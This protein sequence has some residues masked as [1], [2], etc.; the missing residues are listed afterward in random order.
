MRLHISHRTTYAY[1]TP[2]RRAVETLRLTPR[3]HDGQF[4]IGWR[5]DVD[6]DCILEASADPFGNSV[7]SFTA[8]GP[9]ESL[10]ITAEGT[11]ETNDTAGVVHGQ[12]E[13]FPPVFFLRD[14][15]L[16]RADGALKA[17]ADDIAAR[18]GSGGVDLM[19]RVM[20]AIRD[21]MRFEVDLT[22]TGTTAADAFRL[23]HGVC[24]D[25]AH[26]FIA[27]A[28]QLGVPARYAGGYLLAGDQTEAYSA[29]HAWA[30]ALVDDLGWVGFDAANGV[31]PTE[32]YVRVAMGLDYLGAAPVR[33]MRSGGDGEKLSVAIAVDKAVR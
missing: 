13:R 15:A 22:D 30:E 29:G 14:T 27:V 2:A 4:V 8:E 11:I 26:I 9:F 25:F 31:C 33:G 21:R 18:P 24:Q 32:G 6:R 1:Q 16:T 12:V 23:R 7:H 5:I 10:S 28:R 19:H 3:G 17:F 20:G